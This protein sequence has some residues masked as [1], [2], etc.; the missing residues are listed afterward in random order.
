MRQQVISTIQ[1]SHNSCSKRVDFFLFAGICRSCSKH[2]KWYAPLLGVQAPRSKLY[3]CVLCVC[4]LDRVVTTAITMAEWAQNN[5]YICL[6]SRV[7]TYKIY[8]VFLRVYRFDNKLK[9]IYIYFIYPYNNSTHMLNSFAPTTNASSMYS[10]CAIY[11]AKRNRL[12]VY[13]NVLLVYIQHVI[14]S[15]R[16]TR[17]KFRDWATRKHSSIVSIASRRFSRFSSSI[18]T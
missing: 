11:W 2:Y 12:I 16:L 5:C 17:V 14:S 13:W 10:V 3:L 18:T 7:K 8:G 1:T 15:N 6:A 4:I 9:N